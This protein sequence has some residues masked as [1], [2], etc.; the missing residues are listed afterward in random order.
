[1]SRVKSLLL[2]IVFAIGFLSFASAYIMLLTE[3]PQLVPV[4]L[5]V[6][7]VAVFYKKL[8]S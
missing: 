8:R 5:L 4:A 7:T 3:Y 6:L 2:A 1:M